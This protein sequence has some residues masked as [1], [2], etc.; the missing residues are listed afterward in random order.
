MAPA[1]PVTRYTLGFTRP[2]TRSAQSPALA[3]QG[4]ERA[5]PVSTGSLNRG[6]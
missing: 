3:T 2:S 6:R 5:G 1:E 4:G